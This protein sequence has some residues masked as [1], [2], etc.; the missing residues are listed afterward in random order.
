MSSLF[1]SLSLS[2][3][4]SLYLSLSISFLHPFAP[5]PPIWNEEEEKEDKKESKQKTLLYN[6][7]S[8]LILIL[9][10]DMFL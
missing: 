1:L 5:I 8:L 6:L 10:A 4:I 2:L 3:S 9:H 7:R